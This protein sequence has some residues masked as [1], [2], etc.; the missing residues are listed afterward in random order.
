MTRI[1]IT[2]AAGMVG[3]ALLPELEGHEVFATDLKRPESLPEC[4]AFL[5]M[6]VTSD[7]PARVITKVKPDV[8]VHLASIVTPPPKTGRTAAYAV[9][10]DGT[11]K[12]VNAA[13]ANGV[14]RLVV[15]SSGAAYGYHP[16]NRI[17]LRER[18]P[19]RGNPEFPYSDHK[20]QVEELLAEARNT[21]P[22]LEQVVLRVGTVLGAGTE[23]Q[24]T[25]L[26][27][28]PRLLAV[29][30]SES[31]F[32]FIWTHDL[33]RILRRA[34]T[35]GPPGIFNVAG[36]GA[37]GVTDLADAMGKSV[38]RLPA[39]A[40]K[41]ALSVARPLGLSRYGPEQV[42][43]LQYRPVLDNSA[44]KS[45]FGYTPEKTSAEVFAFWQKQAGL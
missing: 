18:D 31:P 40:L 7:A 10:V 14:R 30:G 39:W 34:A 42:R 25:A 11:R 17:P 36:D 9:D 21:A 8:I 43:F 6:D 26:F 12:V 15:T 29:T 33:A 38:L 2:G 22:D 5:P 35:D 23:N 1:L 13:I 37:M 20:R 19:L 32:V 41:A 27:H 4:I 44:L 3:Q 16:D 24:I 28:K 45:E